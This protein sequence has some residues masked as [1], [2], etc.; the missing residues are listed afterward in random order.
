M[1][2]DWH[3]KAS[4]G[5]TD[6][7]ADAANETGTPVPSINQVQAVAKFDFKSWFLP[8]GTGG[9]VGLIIFFLL[10]KRLPKLGAG[11]VAIG[12]ALVSAGVA[13]KAGL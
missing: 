5:E 11:A 7:S 8:F 12:A 9:L 10:K 6:I 13:K 3:N 4:L 1:L 2:A